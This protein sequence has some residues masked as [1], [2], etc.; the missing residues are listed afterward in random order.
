MLYRTHGHPCG[1]GKFA[2]RRVG[3][4][5]PWD[6]LGKVEYVLTCG[7]EQLLFGGGAPVRSF[8]K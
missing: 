4:A 2:E 5:L 8:G 7:R 1:A 3:D 6:D